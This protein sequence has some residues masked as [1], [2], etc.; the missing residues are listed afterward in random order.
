MGCYARRKGELRD[1]E[2]GAER[3]FSDV[4]SSR[5]GRANVGTTGHDQ[6]PTEARLRG[7]GWFD[8]G[9]ARHV[10]QRGTPGDAARGSARRIHPCAPRVSRLARN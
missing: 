6:P 8:V 10:R 1:G 7:D 9:D 5:L 4:S 3:G 2:T